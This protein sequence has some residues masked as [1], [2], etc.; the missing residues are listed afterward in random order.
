M[1]LLRL[2]FVCFL[3]IFTQACKE[4]SASSYSNF[5]DEESYI[6]EE[7]EEAYPDDTYCADVKYYNPDTGTRSNYTLNVEVEDNEVRVIHFSTGWLD[8]SEFSS[9]DLDSD[10][11][12]SIRLYD[13]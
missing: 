12:C 10:G 5:D 4:S 13:G 8:S 1:S 7:E 2:I 11:Y 3:F 6:Y 9:Q